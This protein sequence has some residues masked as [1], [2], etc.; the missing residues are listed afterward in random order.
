MATLLTLKRRIRPAQNVS[1]TTKGM[2]MIAASKLKKA[3]DAALSSRP[4][5]QKLTDLT[6][7]I[8]SKIIPTTTKRIFFFV[9]SVRVLAR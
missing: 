6:Q 1:K 5:V 3:Q 8:A 4:Y 2:Q 7:D 9:L